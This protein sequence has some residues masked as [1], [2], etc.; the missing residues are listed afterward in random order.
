MGSRREEERNEKIIRGLMKLPPNRRCIN[1]NSLGPQYVC[2][3]FWTFIC[4]TCSGIHREFTHRVKSVSMSKFTSQEVEALQN[5]GNQR[6]R[7]MYLKGWD[8]QRQRLPD[9]SN[10]ERVREF[11]KNV[12]VDKRYAVGKTLDIPP[13]DSQGLGGHADETRRA[14]SYHSYSQSPPYDF[15]YEDRRYGKH[16][17]VLTR[18][19]GSDRGVYVGK[20]SSFISSPNH[21]GERVVEDRFANEGS[22]SRVSDYSASS[23]GD[24]LRS[25]PESPNFLKEIGLSSPPYHPSMDILGDHVQ[26]QTAN[27]FSEA[28]TKRDQVGI[29]RPQ[30]TTSLAS[31]SSFDSNAT[32]LKS[33]NSGSLADVV[34]GSLSTTAHLEKTFTFSPSSASVSH[35]NLDLFSAP[36]VP[37]SDSFPTPAIDLF[38]VPTSS[39]TPTVDLFNMPQTNVA[40]SMNSSQTSQI[41]PSAS[42]DFFDGST[43]QQSVATSHKTSLE[44]LVSTNQGWATFDNTSAA[45]KAGAENCRSSDVASSL[46][47]SMK[48]D[49]VSSTTAS[50]QWPEFQNFSSQSFLS[51]PNPWPE[52]LNNVGAPSNASTTQVQIWNAFGDSV[53]HLPADGMKQSSG[54]HISGYNPLLTGDEYLGLTVL[55]STANDEVLGPALNGVPAPSKSLDDEETKLHTTDHRSTNPFDLPYDSELEPSEMFFDMSSLQNVLPTSHL[56]ATLL[57]D[58]TQPWFPQETMTSYA[59]SIP[60][61][62]LAYIAGQAQNPQLASVQTH[63][64]V[65]SIGG[66]PFA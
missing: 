7:D 39:L 28:N 2:T 46:G 48:F 65:A 19:P 26:L 43:L 10:V 58:V 45:S 59:P 24:P 13:S 23:G 55:E 42:L 64:P 17:A 29:P 31:S 53:S 57:G 66:N 49:Q 52:N 51:G 3:N 50:M 22:I 60:Q 6:A 61:G 40:P 37:K 30:R 36:V 11:I 14:S 56:P 44:Q 54:L 16:G 25:G 62:G 9:N 38:Q 32:S 4:M 47:S 21:L 35:G 18:K 20:V 5:G 41:P 8:Y 33:Y 63:E 34:P 1:C 27:L 15:Q 12:Y